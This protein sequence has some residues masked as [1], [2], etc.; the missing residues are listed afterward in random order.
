MKISQAKLILS[1]ALSIFLLNACA[2][3]KTANANS[4]APTADS[5][6]GV[7]ANDDIGLLAA[8]EQAQVLVNATSLGWHP[9]ETP[10]AVDH[11]Q[12]L[13]SDSLVI[14]LTYRDTDLLIAARE[15]G[16]RTLDGLSMLIHQGAR[17]FELWTGQPAPLDVMRQS[18]Q[19]AA[20]ARERS[21]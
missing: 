18:V 21:V 2:G 16:L 4:F 20:A 8:L 7:V 10:L 19:Q 15:R 1:L 17:A 5:K 6:T 12:R 11:L 3:N 9:G 14:D 13:P